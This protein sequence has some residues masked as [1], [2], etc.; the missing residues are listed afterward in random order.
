[1]Q[2]PTNATTATG[3]SG[4]QG[5]QGG[6]NFAMMANG[7]LTSVVCFTNATVG[8]QRHHPRRRA[9]LRHLDAT[10]AAVRCRALITTT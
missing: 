5:H 1:M 2:P 6:A 4:G 7:G 8:V 9:V 3:T 10:L